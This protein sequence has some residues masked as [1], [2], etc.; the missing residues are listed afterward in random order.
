[1]WT[2][3]GKGSKRKDPVKGG[4]FSFALYQF[5]LKLVTRYVIKYSDFLTIY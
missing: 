2:D 5:Y 3:G 1:M 4:N